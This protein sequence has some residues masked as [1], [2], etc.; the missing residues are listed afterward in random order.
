MEKRTY[1][2][3]GEQVIWQTLKN[4]LTVAIVPRPG[5]TKKLCYLP[6]CQIVVFTK[7]SN[8]PIHNITSNAFYNNLKQIID[9]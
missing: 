5:F 9:I 8:A 7:I 2:A 6:L 3:L 1:P 4:G